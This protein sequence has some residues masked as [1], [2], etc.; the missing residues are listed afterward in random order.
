MK[1]LRLHWQDQVPALQTENDESQFL[2]QEAARVVNVP[3]QSIFDKVKTNEIYTEGQQF[4]GN[5]F[6][7]AKNFMESQ[8]AA[9]A[10]P[11]PKTFDDLFY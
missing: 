1:V 2:K 3:A 6:N 9:V 11:K 4:V 5:L 7:K 10:Q 8:T